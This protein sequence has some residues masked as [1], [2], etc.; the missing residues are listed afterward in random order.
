M[1]GV[2]PSIREG[3]LW[4]ALYALWPEFYPLVK[5]MASSDGLP[6]LRDQAQALLE[7]MDKEGLTS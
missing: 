3:G 4:A 5:Q 1:Q 2:D 7:Y 6:I